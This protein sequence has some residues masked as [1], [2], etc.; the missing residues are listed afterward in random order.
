MKIINRK[1]PTFL[2]GLDDKITVPVMSGNMSSQEIVTLRGLYDSTHEQPLVPDDKT[3]FTEEDIAEYSKKL[4]AFKKEVSARDIAAQ[5]LARLEQ[6]SSPISTAF[7]VLNR[8]F[9][10]ATK[11]RR[12]TM[13]ATMVHQCL[14]YFKN[15]NG[16]QGM[17]NADVISEYFGT[18]DKFF[19]G[20][21]SMGDKN[22]YTVK[23]RLYSK[24]KALLKER[25]KYPKNHVKYA[26]Y[27]QAIEQYELILK[28]GEVF[29]SLIV[30]AA[31]QIKENENIKYDLNF[32]YTVDDDKLEEQYAEL[33]YV[34]LEETKKEGWQEHTD[35]IS[36]F[37]SA[38]RSVRAALQFL[39][40]VIVDENGNP[41]KDT[42]GN[43]QYE[44]DDM[45]IR[46][47]EDPMLLHRGLQEVHADTEQ[48]FLD[49]LL[50]LGRFNTAYLSLY[51]K[52]VSNPKLL[53]AFFQEY[54]KTNINYRF[55]DRGKGFGIAKLLSGNMFSKNRIWNSWLTKIRKV[56]DISTNSIFKIVE[57]EFS[58]EDYRGK[59]VKSKKAV[60]FDVAKVKEFKEFVNEWFV[61]SGTGAFDTTKYAAQSANK[62]KELMAKLLT[63][64]NISTKTPGNKDI[65]DNIYRGS[66]SKDIIKEVLKLIETGSLDAKEMESMTA[67]GVI[68]LTTGSSKASLMKDPIQN[69]LY[70]VDKQKPRK[71][72]LSVRFRDKTLF[73]TVLPS[74][75]SKIIDSFK[76][77]ASN[78]AKL[79]KIIEN[80]YLKSSQFMGTL[81]TS[82]E[83]PVIYNRLLR[84]LYQDPSMQDIV[85]NILSKF[86]ISRN[87]GTLDEDF[88][89][90]TEAEHL[91]VL[92]SEYFGKL[93][94][95]NIEYVTLDE[96]KTR[97]EAKEL[98]HYTDYYIV[99][100]P[101]YFR[102]SNPTKH[103]R[104]QFAN[105]STFILGDANQLKT[106][107][108]P[109]YSYEECIEGLYHMALSEIAFYKQKVALNK[110]I[111]ENGGDDFLPT[112]NIFGYL[113]FLNNIDGLKSIESID[114]STNLKETITNAIREFL[115]KEREDIIKALEDGGIKESFLQSVSPKYATTKKEQILDT[116]INDF[117]ANYAL[118]L[119]CVQQLTTVSASLFEGAKDIAKRN[120][121]IHSNG[122][123][124]NTEAWNP[125]T[126]RKFKKSTEDEEG[127]DIQ[128]VIIAKE[129]ALKA[130][131]IDP[132][133]VEY[134][135]KVVGKDEAKPYLEKLIKSTD[136]QGYRLIDSY[137][138]IRTMAGEGEDSNLDA[139]YAKYKELQARMRAEGKGRTSF[140]Q[141]EIAELEEIGYTPQPIKPI[142][143]AINQI[144]LNNEDTMLIS[145]QHKYAEVILIPEMLPEGSRLKAIAEAMQA[146]NPKDLAEGK[147]DIDLV[148]FNS[149]VKHGSYNAVEIY[150]GNDGQMSYDEVKNAIR[151][152]YETM[153]HKVALKYMK[154]QTNSP[155]HLSQFRA[156][157]TQLRKVFLQGINLAGN[158]S[159]YFKSFAQE[160]YERIRISATRNPRID[161]F[162]GSDYVKFYNALISADYIESFKDLFKV[163][164][165]K[166]K[167]GDILSQQTIYGAR[168]NINDTV[169]YT[170]EGNRFLVPLFD[171]IREHDVAANFLSLYRKA[172]NKQTTLGGS[173]V[174]ASAFGIT[175]KEESE[176]LK[177]VYEEYTD[178]KGNTSKRIIGAECELA[179]DFKITNSDGTQTDLEFDDWCNPDG[180]FKVG[181]ILE[182]SDPEYTK[183]H[184]YKTEDGKVFKPAIEM[185]YPN[186]LKLIAYRVPTEDFYSV[187]NL[188]VVRCTRKT[189][190]GGTIKVPMQGVAQAGF[191]FDIDKLY[192]IR[193]EYKK[194]KS[195]ISNYD[196]WTA[197]YEE[198]P[199]IAEEL[200][201]AQL[202][203][204]VNTGESKQL[205]EYWNDPDVKATKGL[206]REAE[207]AKQLAKMQKVYE[208]YDPSKT[209]LENT[210]TARH[211]MLFE[212]LWARMSDPETARMRLTPGGFD[213]ARAAAKFIREILFKKKEYRNQGYTVK[214]LFKKSLTTKE[215][216]PERSVIS[217][218]TILRFNKMNQ[219]ADKLIGVFAN[220][221]SN[222]MMSS[223]MHK[224][225]LNPQNAIKFGSLISRNVV[226]RRG[227]IA[228]DP[229]DIGSTLLANVVEIYDDNG[230]LESSYD[231]LTSVHEYIAA[232]VDAV[233]DPVLD[234]LGITTQAAHAAVLLG[235]LGYTA[236][237]VG[238]LFNQPIV[239]EYLKLLASGENK[240]SALRAIKKKY[241]QEGSITPTDS[242]LL[243][244][245][246]MLNNLLAENAL[247]SHISDQLAYIDL[248]ANILN[249]GANLNEFVKMTKNSASN[250][251]SSN[252]SKLY[253]TQHSYEKMSARVED[254][255]NPLQMVLSD[256]ENASKV[257]LKALD[258]NSM[259]FEEYLDAILDSPFA[260]EQA[261]YDC[262]N[263]FMY[264]IKDIFPYETKLYKAIRAQ[265]WKYSL[266]DHMS[267]ETI[268]E[269]HHDIIIKALSN[270]GTSFFNPNNT[271]TFMGNTYK[272]SDFYLNVFPSVLEDFLTNEV[273]AKYRREYP[274]FDNIEI[275]YD[276]DGSCDIV[277]QGQKDGLKDSKYELSSSFEDAIYSDDNLV[278]SI[279]TCMIMYHYFKN[280]FA[281]TKTSFAD[282]ISP[283]AM[284]PILANKEGE[285]YY[286][287]LNLLLDED[288]IIEIDPEDMITQFVQ[289][290]SDNKDFV[291]T[292]KKSEVI[293]LFKSSIQA[294][295]NQEGEEIAFCNIPVDKASEYGLCY[296]L[297]ESVI[298]PVK[299]IKVNGVLYKAEKD[300]YPGDAFEIKYIAL[301][302]LGVDKKKSYSR[303]GKEL[304]LGDVSYLQENSVKVPEVKPG[305][306]TED[307]I[308][309]VFN[310]EGY[311]LKDIQD[312]YLGI[313]ELV[314]GK[315][316]T[317]EDVNTYKS[318]DRKALV[319]SLTDIYNANKAIIVIDVQTKELLRM[320]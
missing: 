133:F 275:V 99:G 237:D 192:L 138:K 281:F 213:K 254:E 291:R 69:I 21:P 234:Y 250:S 124:L 134:I 64:L 139:W 210:K 313:M 298:K 8:T 47:Y 308:E 248:F 7:L 299:F 43:I 96:W 285:T 68:K 84:D 273:Y 105:F 166:R 80:G 60:Y 305:N 89:E 264:L 199:D 159:R 55:L 162:T 179:F 75:L 247:E 71:K 156:F 163:F 196:V 6:T 66:V 78:I 183:Y 255:N 11:V 301:E 276:E 287:V 2:R 152:S 236:T 29:K 171:A 251:V 18:P 189:A 297:P 103:T 120:K 24:Y 106:I 110:I 194:V 10:G 238:L 137:Y 51:G 1:C 318:L 220:H 211:N 157:G 186:I 107:T 271:V 269:L 48:E 314:N 229:K 225:N 104:N 187:M 222:A 277:V 131:E 256:D 243:T 284:M 290:H 184:M 148:I 191:D 311:K 23:G 5:R 63:Y 61:K 258:I 158:Y 19:F 52:L 279:A 198:H 173:A 206:D 34:V 253:E 241:N 130:E 57:G 28:N 126:K 170:P 109:V 119:A 76:Y 270:R 260:F 91:E 73:N 204:K 20:D 296:T 49:N 208:K 149:G 118:S 193:Y 266:N 286:D 100:E 181:K 168:G 36:S 190:T 320:C 142:T 228:V 200:L 178:D 9:R 15:V 44:L 92:L 117:V 67:E 306:Y 215:P 85:D 136:G 22:L 272:S 125:F 242:K 108:H 227:S 259:D 292:Y 310:K 65:I 304:S 112:G 94:T 205:F 303:R 46:Y 113:H 268:T 45:F 32:S 180:T 165:D 25:E 267:E 140:T 312:L 246:N 293:D 82:K 231:I 72:E 319:K 274:I 214:E 218:N 26:E 175:K 86:D 262:N 102:G 127:D 141:E 70:L 288:G 315:S 182:P 122:K 240:T 294:E 252:F 111:E 185:E 217:V 135:K 62:K 98:R 3:E 161:G 147:C 95:N 53:S 83:G 58:E 221:N 295:T 207:F 93:S 14:E 115:S 257:P 16:I 87:L 13:M 202:R 39:P 201:A 280:G 244:E 59:K 143:Q 300:S 302:T 128:T 27:T 40:K 167:L 230:E 283:I 169:A 212:L 316:L 176:N 38:K 261:A 121:G 12:I 164:K 116:A 307:Y 114:E 160:G 226:L 54:S 37:K 88:S 151:A 145:Q 154:V 245:D 224:L 30:A 223:L 4:S 56:K 123:D 144:A 90:F 35:E 174:Q 197:Y 50:V 77:S 79:R 97:K 33:E 41:R 263:G 81:D 233:K 129:V 249:M 155:E 31:S 317:T 132:D 101:Y 235:R 195:D 177:Y 232:A 17:S 278:R 172:V 188:H 209:P 265:G 203:D 74:L 289:N 282:M 219:I 216:E 309:E 146:S 150:K 153:P 239:Q 42:K